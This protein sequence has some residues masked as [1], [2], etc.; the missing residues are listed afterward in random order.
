MKTKI[1]KTPRDLVKE[2]TWTLD[3]M[4]EMTVSAYV[5]ING[6]GT[7]DLDD[8]FGYVTTTTYTDAY[9]FAAGLNIAEAGK[10][11]LPVLSPDFS[12][13]KT[14]DLLNYLI[15]YFH[16]NDAIYLKNGDAVGGLS[17]Y[18]AVR[19][20]FLEKRSL[21]ILDQVSS[22]EIALRDSTVAYGIVPLPKYDEK[23]ENYRT[24]MSFPYSLYGVPIDAKNPDMSVAVLECLGSEGYRNVSPALFETAL[25][26]K[27]SSDNKTAE[28]Y[29]ILRATVSFDIGRIF[30]DSM[31]ALTYSMFRGALDRGTG[32]WASIY[33]SNEAT[34]TAKFADVINALATGE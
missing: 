20:T 15:D 21:F 9:Y 25:K 24:T 4:K 34:L 16:N 33:K 3:K 31:N 27:Y 11:G 12:S 5:D 19:K 30:N 7:Q 32:D 10:D 26:V 14:H 28:M 1:S 22:A 29:D 13:E 8:S 18:E 17:C 23:Q 6:N 2:G